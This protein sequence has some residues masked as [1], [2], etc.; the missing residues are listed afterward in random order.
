[1]VNYTVNMMSQPD[2]WVVK[3][4]VAT[5]EDVTITFTDEQTLTVTL[6]SLLNGPLGRVPIPG[7]QLVLD[8]ANGS[9]KPHEAPASASGRTRDGSWWRR[10]A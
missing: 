1:M 2:F 6:Q 7:D 8:G 9:V 5:G 3:Q 10:E 4:V